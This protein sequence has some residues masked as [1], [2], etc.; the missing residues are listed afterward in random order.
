MNVVVMELLDVRVL[1]VHV[2]VAEEGA[3]VVLVNVKDSSIVS[4]T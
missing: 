4:D 2:H 1:E 3:H